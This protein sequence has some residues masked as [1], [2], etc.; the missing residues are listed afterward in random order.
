MKVGYN[1]VIQLAWKAFAFAQAIYK[2]WILLNIW[3]LLGFQS[4]SAGNSTADREAGIVVP[5]RLIGNTMIVE[6]QINGKSGDFL[7]DTGAPDLILNSE[8]FTGYNDQFETTKVTGIHGNVVPVQRY[9]AKEIALSGTVVARSNAMVFDLTSLESIKK[10]PIA[11]ILGYNVF[12]DYELQV[13]FVCQ[14]IKL[15]SIDK[16][17]RYSLH[18]TAT[19][20]DSIEFKMSGH[21]PYLNVQLLGKKLRL[22]IDFGSE[23]NVLQADVINL[24]HFEIKGNLQLAGLTH[25]AHRQPIGMVTGFSIGNLDIEKLEVVLTDFK[26]ASKELPVQLHGVLGVSFFRQYKLSINYQSKK[27]YVWPNTEM[28]GE[29]ALTVCR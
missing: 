2:F 16:R 4:V 6:A 20:S 10:Q 21:I 12:K 19:P 22:G 1:L 13:D 23:R 26:R 18:K 15:F 5:F 11:G 28:G 8:Y 9:W 27:I 7:F 24:Q 29:G 17:N 3:L 25:D 14:H